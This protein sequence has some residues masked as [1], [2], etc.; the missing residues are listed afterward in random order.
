MTGTANN[1]GR[2]IFMPIM[3]YCSDRYGR[4]AILIVGVFSS[5]IFAYIRSYA[6]TYGT[7][8]AFELL[9]SGIGSVTYSASFILAM[10]WIG[11][12]DRVLLG[13]IVTATYPF[14]QLFLGFTARFVRNFR[15]L[16][17]IIYGPGF[18]ILLYFWIAP[19]SVR[20]LIVN[21]KKSRLIKTLQKAEH[22]N[23]MKISDHTWDVLSI[24]L[25]DQFNANE[26]ND[27]SL[28]SA[29]GCKQIIKKRIFLIRF[30]VC[31]LLW[32]TSAFVSYGM[33]LTSVGLVGDK[34][35]NFMI[36]AI[37]GVPAMLVCYFLL[38]SCGRRWT[39]CS[40]FLICGAS[41]I[42]SKLLPAHF[43]VL[44]ITL[45]FIGKVFITVAFTSLYVYTSELWPT[46]MRHSMMGFCSTVGRVGAILANLA[47]LLVSYT[48]FFGFDRK[49]RNTNNNHLE[50]IHLS[51]CI[52]RHSALCIICFNGRVS[53]I[54]FITI[55]RN[56]TS[57]IA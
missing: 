34:Y 53:R 22:V 49:S 32:L 2:F 20:W 5:A 50:S 1:I 55:T 42:G 8:L 37:A 33:S 23:G 36:V 17:R 44:S 29:Q 51:G 28:P 31:A 40:S 12:K 45:F 54:L 7:F 19:E 26:R 52:R 16:L 30:L 18:L 13:A 38:E 39:L 3:S 11:V 6:P 4:R 15:Y 48:Y 21:K 47:P 56:I 24:Q 43:S 10:E 46:F 27:P 14:G 9:D 35:A 57:Q 25:Q 41:I